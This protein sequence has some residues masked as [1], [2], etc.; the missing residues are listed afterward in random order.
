MSFPTSK[1]DSV[2]GE[3]MKIV[4]NRNQQ[5][6]NLAVEFYDG[7][8]HGH[9][10]VSFELWRRVARI[11]GAEKA[12]KLDTARADALDLLNY[13]AF[14]VMLLD[15]HNHVGEKWDLLHPPPQAAGGPQ[16][17][18]YYQTTIEHTMEQE[19]YVQ[20][21]RNPQPRAVGCDGAD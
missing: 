1:Y 3:A 17:E 12:E 20:N 9:A 5:G 21:S 15:R 19:G 13:A 4:A 10:D 14:Y 6:R 11:L 7:F 2:L 16:A 18:K 8:P